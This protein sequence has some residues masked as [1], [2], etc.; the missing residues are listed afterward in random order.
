MKYNYISVY[1]NNIK[2][3]IILLIIRNSLRVKIY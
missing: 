3:N 1:K 2:V